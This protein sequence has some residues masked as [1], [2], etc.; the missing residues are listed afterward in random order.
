MNRGDVFMIGLLVGV[1]IGV[2]VLAVGLHGADASL[3]ME[4]CYAAGY[5]EANEINDAWY[6]V[7]G[8]DGASVVSVDTLIEYLSKYKEG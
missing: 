8:E 3:A 5:D 6:C 2:V 7:S 1:C 4:M